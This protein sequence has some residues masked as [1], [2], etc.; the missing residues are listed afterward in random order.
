MVGPSEKPSAPPG[1]HGE[2]AWLQRWWMT[3]F[4]TLRLLS[5]TQHRA[6]SLRAGPAQGPHLGLSHILMAQLSSLIQRGL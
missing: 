4:P 3:P 6:V 1:V 5:V 2:L